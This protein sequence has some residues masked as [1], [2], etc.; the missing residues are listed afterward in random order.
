LRDYEDF[1]RAFGGIAKA[2]AVWSWSG[3][4]RTVALTVAGVAGDVPAARDIANLRAAIARVADTAIALIILPYRPAS[5]RLAATVR[6]DPAFVP[7]IVRAAVATALADA[8]SFERRE[9]GQRVHRSEVIAVMQGVPGVAWIDLDMLYRGDTPALAVAI[10]AEAPRSGLR[11]GL[12]V[13]PLA[14]ELLVLNSAALDL[15]V[16]A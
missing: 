3:T 1:A 12:G 7:D 14:A 9:L 15:R 8:F 6:T 10:P 2:Q 16:I 13:Q 4:A 5:F 11:L